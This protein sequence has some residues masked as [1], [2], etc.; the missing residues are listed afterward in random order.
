VNDSTPGSHGPTGSRARHRDDGAPCM[1][2]NLLRAGLPV[3]VW[4][5]TPEPAAALAAEGALAHELPADAVAHADV[6]ITMLPHAEAVKSVAFDRGMLAAMRPGAVWAQ[7]GHRRRGGHQRAGRPGCGRAPDVHFVDAPVSGT[8]GPAEAGQLLILASGRGG[9]ACARARV[10][11]DRPG[12]RRVA[13]R[14]GRGHPAQAG[15]EQLAGLPGRGNRGDPGAGGLA[16]RRS[17]GGAGIPRRRKP[18][19]AVGAREVPQDGRRGNDSPDFSLQWAL[20]DIRLA[21][22]AASDVSLPVLDAIGRRWDS[23]VDEG[24]GGLDV[25]AV[26]HGLDKAAAG[27]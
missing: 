17:P 18:G 25:S 10:R 11:G 12:V 13:R 1:A 20:K 23:L 26:R 7:D 4:N 24:M 16:R 6:V 9:Q 5:R 27:R 14:G 8:R 15:H 21:L 19:L 22:S 3:D 2:R